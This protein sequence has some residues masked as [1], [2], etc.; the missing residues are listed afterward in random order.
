MNTIASECSARSAV[1]QAFVV[2]DGNAQRARNVVDRRFANT[3]AVAP[4]VLTVVV[5]PFVSMVLC[6]ID[7]VIAVPVICAYT[8]SHV[9]SA[10]PVVVP[11]FASTIGV[12]RAVRKAARLSSKKNSQAPLL[13]TQGLLRQVM[14]SSHTSCFKALMM[15]RPSTPHMISARRTI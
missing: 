15:Q 13:L 6:D 10:Y 8:T 14:C 11:P 2:T 5:H 1:D 9:P 12:A 7:V 4:S 3:I